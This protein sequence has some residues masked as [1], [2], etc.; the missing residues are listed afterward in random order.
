[1]TV[2]RLRRVA[3]GLAILLAPAPLLAAVID[4]GAQTST[5]TNLT[6]GFSFTAPTDFVIV[7]LDLPTDASTANFD[8]AVFRFSTLNASHGAASDY[9][10]LFDARDQSAALTG[11]SIAVSAGDV[12]GIL[13]SRDATAINSY[14]APDYASSILGNAVTL[15]RLILQDTLRSA[16]FPTG[17]Q[18]GTEA[19]SPIGFVMVT[20]AGPPI[21]RVLVTQAGP[22]IG[23]V[24]V[25][26]QAASISAVPLPG[27]LPLMALGL[28]ALVLVRRRG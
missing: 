12:I 15:Q 23:R 25:D 9:D 11:L 17:A 4:I 16:T 7:G 21:G 26:V 19:G 2:R 28:G 13:G 20:E 6:R 5:F 10:V 24:L 1:M 27:A 3:L 8:V 14:G 18:F 22:P